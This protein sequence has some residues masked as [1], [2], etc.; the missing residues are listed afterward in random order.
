ME[1]LGAYQRTSAQPPPGNKPVYTARKACRKFIAEERMTLIVFVC[2]DDNNG[3]MFNKRRQSRDRCVLTDML[4][5][6]AGSVLWMNAYSATLFPKEDGAAV[7]IDERFMEKAAPGE[8]CFAENVQICPY[9]ER[10]EKLVLYRW[11]RNYPYDLQFDLPL[12]NHGWKRAE[13]AE[14]KGS[15]HEKIT[16][17]T[18]IK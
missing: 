18:Y 17:E 14:F 8:F 9:E 7:R 5:E 1:T 15:S 11:N 2:L 3:M 6:S 4:R 16:K 12:E 13:T 10:I